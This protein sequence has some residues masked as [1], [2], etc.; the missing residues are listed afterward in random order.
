MSDTALESICITG[1]RP[2]YKTPAWM[3]G[4]V[5]EELRAQTSHAKFRQT[6]TNRKT[7]LRPK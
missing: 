1:S 3:I 6:D 4:E 5:A 2:P 7:Q